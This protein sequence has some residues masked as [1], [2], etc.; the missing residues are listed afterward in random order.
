M[1]LANKV[2]IVTGGASGFGAGIVRRFVAEGVTS[3]ANIVA[4]LAVLTE[5][6]VDVIKTENLYTFDGAPGFS[7]GQGQ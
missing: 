4:L 2:A 6:G 7:L 3:Q 5:G 1:R